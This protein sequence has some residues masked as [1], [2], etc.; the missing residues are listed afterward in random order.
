MDTLQ[1]AST[2]ASLLVRHVCAYGDLVADDVSKALAA[3]GRRVMMAVVAVA[4]GMFA[5][6]MACLWAV[7]ITWDT[8]ARLWLIGGLAAAFALV[9]LWALVTLRRLVVDSRRITRTGAE[10]QKDRQLLDELLPPAPD[11]IP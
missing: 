4:A 5:V 3:L 11:G 1:R 10:W 7:V 2:L 8:A 9:A 6:G